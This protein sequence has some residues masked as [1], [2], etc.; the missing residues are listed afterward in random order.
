MVVSGTLMEGRGVAKHLH[1]YFN[2]IELHQSYRMHSFVLTM[3]KLN[4]SYGHS[5]LVRKH[6]NKFALNL[7]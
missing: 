7:N 3:D 6:A 2:M 5:K 1:L 4:S